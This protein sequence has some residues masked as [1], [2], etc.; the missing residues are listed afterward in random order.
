MKQKKKHND[1]RQN[2]INM[3]N[4]H[5]AT[6]T[7]T[8]KPM[9]PGTNDYQKNNYYI[10]TDNKKNNRNTDMS[11]GLE[12]KKKLKTKTM[13]QK[14]E[15]PSSPKEAAPTSSSQLLQ[16]P[17]SEVFD[18]S[19]DNAMSEM[20]KVADMGPDETSKLFSHLE[21]KQQLD[22]STASA[23]DIVKKTETENSLNI[24]PP[25]ANPTLQ[26]EIDHSE[27]ASKKEEDG[28]LTHDEKLEIPQ[29][30]KESERQDQ[31]GE[32]VRLNDELNKEHRSNSLNNNEN[33][34]PFISGIKLWQAY[35]ELWNDAYRWYMKTWKSVFK[36]IRRV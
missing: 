1:K 31:I 16:P 24:N 33:N 23:D 21:D 3:K 13:D 4:K 6:S 9:I 27:M 32:S 18:S 8:Y 30:H 10:Q 25:K 14:E 12:D 28:L 5:T 11:M 20:N 2:T 34:N 26:K 36:T 15:K 19:S 22:P 35:S 7:A 29:I 17:E